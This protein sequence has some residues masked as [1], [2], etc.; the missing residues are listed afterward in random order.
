MAQREERALRG[1]SDATRDA[2]LRSAAAAAIGDRV[3]LDANGNGIQDTGEPGVGGVAVSLL[4]GTTVVATT[5]TDATGAYSFSTA[6][7]AGLC[8]SSTCLS[9]PGPKTREIR[10]PT[11]PASLRSAT[12]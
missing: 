11:A 8:S 5:T 1:A 10:M 2:G 7:V 9:S 6:A 12:R 4:N 3:W